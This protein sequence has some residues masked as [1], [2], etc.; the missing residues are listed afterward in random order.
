MIFDLVY[1][2]FLCIYFQTIVF[3]CVKDKSGFDFSGYID[4]ASSL[5]D[6][7]RKTPGCINWPKV[8]AGT[9]L[10]RPKPNDLSFYDWHQDKVFQNDSVN[11]KIINDVKYGL[12]FMHKG[13]HKKFCTN[14]N[15]NTPQHLRNCTK[16]LIESPLYGPAIIYDHIIRKKC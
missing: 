6:Y 1:F 15:E 16:K 11:W 7:F 13:D 3:I 10:L 2:L 12:T 4:F 14:F 9:T 5:N 8:F